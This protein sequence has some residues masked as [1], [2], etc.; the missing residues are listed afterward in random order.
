VF[1]ANWRVYGVRKV[2][3]QLRHEGIDVA[4][5]NVVRLTKNMGIQGIIRAKPRRTTIPD[6]KAPCPL[7]KVN[8]QF[9]VHAPNMLWV[10]DFI[11]E[12]PIQRLAL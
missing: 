6:K 1:E 2:W 12:V 7:D 11:R 9:R 10:S 5:C 8:G 3:R 4:R